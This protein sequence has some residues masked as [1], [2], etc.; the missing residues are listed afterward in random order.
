[1]T[2]ELELREELDTGRTANDEYKC[3][4]GVWPQRVRKYGL[5]AA[6]LVAGV[7]NPAEPGT[8]C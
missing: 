2:E 6:Q 5:A 4:Y 8:T 1:M 3:P 7:H